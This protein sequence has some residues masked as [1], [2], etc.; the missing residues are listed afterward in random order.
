MNER[1][2]V[3]TPPGKWEVEGKGA[4]SSRANGTHV[5]KLA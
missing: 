2:S 5:I 3:G 4:R 1:N